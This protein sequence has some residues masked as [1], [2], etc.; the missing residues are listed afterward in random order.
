MLLL[1][2]GQGDPNIQHLAAHCINS[3]Q[4]SFWLRFDAQPKL[5]WRP[6]NNVL[7]IDGH[8]INF[9]SIFWRDNVFD[10]QGQLCTL[11]QHRQQSGACLDL[12]QAYIAGHSGLRRFNRAFTDGYCNKPLILALAQKCG[13]TIPKTLITNQPIDTHNP[14]TQNPNTQNPNT[15]GPNTLGPNTLGPNTLGPLDDYIVKPI[16]GGKFTE[17]L[18]AYTMPEAPL[19]IIVQQKLAYPELRIYRIGHEYFSIL[20]N[21]HELDHRADRQSQITATATPTHLQTALEKLTN[22][23]GL[24]F[25]AADF[26]SDPKTGAWIFLEVN[27]NP[28]FAGVDQILGGVIARAMIKFLCP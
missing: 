20:I 7:E 23:I 14:D 17:L 1:C 4:P 18:S 28:M 11:P 3:A 6:E 5:N 10:A 19:P 26:K 15:L 27:S 22:I 24:D 12:L 13:L 25:A 16:A 9:S 21:S 8:Q 2:G